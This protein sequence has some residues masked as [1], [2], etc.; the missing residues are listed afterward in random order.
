MVHV[1]WSGY[2]PFN[3][4]ASLCDITPVIPHLAKM[5]INCHTYDF[6]W[7]A[8]EDPYWK[9]QMTVPQNHAHAMLAALFHYGMHAPDVMRWLGGSY[10]G[11]CRD[12]NAT[13]KIL[14]DHNIDPW[15]ISQYI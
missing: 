10:T 9:E 2:L 3:S 8:F 13:V 6:T 7:L 5:V 1:L 12:I 11:K 4:F 15:Q 14:V